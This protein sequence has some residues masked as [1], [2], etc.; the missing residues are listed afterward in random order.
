MSYPLDN[1][2]DYNKVRDD[3][4]RMG[5]S[6]EKLYKAIGDNAVNKQA[7]GIFRNGV[8]TGC[9][10]TAAFFTLAYGGYKGV[11]Y[12]LGCKQALKEEEQL[13]AFF[14]ATVK[15]QKTEIEAEMLENELIE[16]IQKEG[17]CTNGKE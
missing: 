8:L 3:L 11:K 5:G 14:V 13:K 7:P 9:A 1:L 12:L 4:K 17:E 10:G 15:K 16:G 6:V 2:G